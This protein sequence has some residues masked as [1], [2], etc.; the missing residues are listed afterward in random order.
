MVNEEQSENLEIDMHNQM[1]K[2]VKICTLQSAYAVKDN[3][4][5]ATK[6]TL[7]HCSFG[8]LYWM[9]RSFM[10]AVNVFPA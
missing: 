1:C 3:I 7:P 8:L 9:R 5:Y 6:R 4:E 2:Y 10:A